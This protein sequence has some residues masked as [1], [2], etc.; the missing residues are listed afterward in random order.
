MQHGNNLRNERLLILDTKTGLHLVK[1][2]MALFQTYKYRQH[3]LLT[4]S[5]KPRWNQI[6]PQNYLEPKL[7]VCTL[8][9]ILI[10]HK[11]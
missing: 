9:W 2:P 4:L 10:R 11:F 3:I 6:V 7:K 5:S 8:I 1:L